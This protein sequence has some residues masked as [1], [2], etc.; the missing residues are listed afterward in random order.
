M[1]PINSVRIYLVAIL[2]LF[3]SLCGISPNS[4]NEYKEG[5]KLLQEGRSNILPNKKS[6]F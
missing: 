5:D 1:L 2:H 6:F 3:T 4:E